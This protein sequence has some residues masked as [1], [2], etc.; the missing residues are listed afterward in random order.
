LGKYSALAT[1]GS[2][3]RAGAGV[4]IVST[5]V[6]GQ[7]SEPITGT[8]AAGSNYAGIRG[9]MTPG[10]QSTLSIDDAQAPAS[11]EPLISGKGLS[12]AQLDEESARLGYIAE[13][14]R[15]LRQPFCPLNG[16]M[17]LLPFALL[18][19][20]LS[21]KELPTCIR[22]DLNTLRDVTRLTCPVTALVT[23]MESE[24]GFAELMRRVGGQRSSEGRF[25]K[26]F[27]LWSFPTQENLDALASHACG[28]FE[29]WVYALFREEGGLN[30]PGNGKLFS[31]LCK[32]R[33]RLRTRLRAVL[34][35]GFGCEGEQAQD[36]ILLSGCYFA[37]TGESPERQ[38]FVRGAVE[39][40]V[41]QEEELQWTEQALIEDQRYRRA[42]QFCMIINGALVL[43]L[44]LLMA[45]RLWGS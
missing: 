19:D 27:K 9:T 13:L 15:R 26:G 10:I 45:Y 8:A 28:S 32:M 37:A 17:T 23:G 16:I 29:D 20:T 18:E 5:L 44:I 14:V 43:A 34:W 31:L 3:G 40:L 21:A 36:A 24:A 33:S 38:A 7:P 4:S 41:Q 30:R 12:R 25:G 2:R 6:A 22:H 11:P 1:A 35:G 42:A 39:K